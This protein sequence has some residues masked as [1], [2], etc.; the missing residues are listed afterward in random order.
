MLVNEFGKP[1]LARAF[2]DTQ[3][4]RTRFNLKLSTCTFQALEIRR[5]LRLKPP[6]CSDELW[7]RLESL[8]EFYTAPIGGL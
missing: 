5:N 1:F 2:Q 7:A 4:L 6:R 8:D 3:D